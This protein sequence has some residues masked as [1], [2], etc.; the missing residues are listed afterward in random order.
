MIEVRNL[1]MKYDREPVVR[2]VSLDIPETGITALIGPNGA[3][4][5]TMLTGIGRLN[6]IESGEVLID[7]VPV[8][9][10]KSDELAR[11]I[12]VLRQENHL[13]IRLTV[14]ELVMLGRHPHSGG[15]V[16][17]DDHEHV[18]RALTSVS[19]DEMADRFVGELSGGQR[20][21]AFI[22]MTLAQDTKY[23]LLDE[24]L[25][26]LD[27]RHSRDMMR[28]LRTATDERGISAVIVIHDINVAAAYA[29]RIVAMKDGEIRANGTP[30][31]V[32]SPE[33][34][35]DIFGLEVEVGKIGDRLVAMPVA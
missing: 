10:W 35:G 30:E 1:Y 34:L 17:K 11:T 6:P 27:M 24:P 15:R 8:D 33:V 9:K 19:M 32:M 23:V 26:S 25:S 7:G 28:H 16:K 13:A 2:D 21:R 12:A 4:K 3:G 29:D 31:E 14:A 22:A 20:Q 5:S 18:A